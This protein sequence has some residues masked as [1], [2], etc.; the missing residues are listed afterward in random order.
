M[1][2]ARPVHETLM[3]SLG[4]GPLHFALI[5][6]EKQPPERAGLIAEQAE[7]AGTSAVL[8]G[9]TTGMTNELL[10]RTVQAVKSRSQL[11]VILFPSGAKAVTAKADAI[12][13]MSMLNSRAP[14]FL[15]EE[16]ALGAQVVKA[17]G[18]EPIGVGYIVVEPGGAVGK[19]GEAD[20]VRRGD[21]GRAVSYALAAEFF[22]MQYVYLEAGSG[23]SSP[24]PEEMVRAV[25]KEIEVPLIVGGGIRTRDQA[26]AI[27]DAGADVI[28]T[29]NVLEG[30]V[31]VKET[32]NEMLSHFF[33]DVRTRLEKM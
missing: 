31:D 14:R 17:L 19:V 28:V 27:L 8:V 10:D 1:P 9:G 5:D 18:L 3:R 26:K 25:K 33:R 6:P 23:A 2:R 11:P 32:V 22:G 29:G 4:K 7:K 20:L 24:V 30:V 12:F 21:V 15:I 13:F 16:Q